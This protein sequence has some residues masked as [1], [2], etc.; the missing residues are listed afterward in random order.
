[1]WGVLPNSVMLARRSPGGA[2]GEVGELL[3]AEETLGEDHVGAGGAVGVGPLDRGV[4]AL[5]AARVGAGDDHHVG[6]GAMR[7]HRR[8]PD[9]GEGVG[10]D[11]RLVVEVSAAL[12]EDLVLDRCS[13]AAPAW[14]YSTTVRIAALDLA[15]AGV[16][17]D[18]RRQAAARE[19]S[20]IV[21]HISVS[22]MSPMSG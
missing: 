8:R 21:R 4:E 17:V 15:V 16:G 1:M 2:L 13:A 3:L 11:E 10:R 12:R 18:D 5:D 14:P 19:T 22:V 6:I 20:R 7:R 9:G